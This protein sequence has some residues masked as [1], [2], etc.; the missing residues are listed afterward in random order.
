MTKALQRIQK[1]LHDI[2]KEPPANV[3]AGPISDDLMHWQASLMGPQGTPY[4]GGVFFL[5]VDFPDDYPFHPPVLTFK[6]PI[7][8]PNIG[9][10]GGIR[11]DILG[12]NWS[13]ALTLSKVMMSLSSLL[14]DPNPDDPYPGREAVAQ[15]YLRD[16]HQFDKDAAE[17]TDKHAR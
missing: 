11:L 3:S 12:V 5:S 13:P 17:A 7:H 10:D 8:H 6:T 1:E 9:D 14:S 4:Q 2:S 15:S 16:R